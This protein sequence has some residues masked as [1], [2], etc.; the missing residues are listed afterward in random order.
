MRNTCWRHSKGIDMK[1]EIP[2]AF[3]KA[4]REGRVERAI[5]DDNS[6]GRRHALKVVNLMKA[7]ELCGMRN[8]SIEEIEAMAIKV[9]DV[10]FEDLPRVERRAF[11]NELLILKDRLG[12]GR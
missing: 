11:I 10:P 9:P 7:L 12:N 4:M 5:R 3:K 8:Y 6:D 2:E 1:N